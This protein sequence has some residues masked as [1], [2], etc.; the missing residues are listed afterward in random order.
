MSLSVAV[1]VSASDKEPI[2]PVKPSLVFEQE[3]HSTAFEQPRGERRLLERQDERL[4]FIWG[5]EIPTSR[6]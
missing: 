6:D 4:D 2:E 5:V 3:R 1:T